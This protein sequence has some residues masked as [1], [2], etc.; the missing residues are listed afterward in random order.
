MDDASAE[1]VPDLIGVPQLRRLWRRTVLA[2]GEAV[3][4]ATWAADQAA[5][6]G[7]GLGLHETMAF[8]HAT[9]PD[10]AAFERWVLACNGGVMDAAR[11]AQVNAVVARAESGAVSP[12]EGLPADLAPVLDADDLRC[13]AEKGYVVLREAVSPEDCRAAAEAIWA[14]TG[15]SPDEP[16]RW[17]DAR[18]REGIFVTLARHPAFEKNRRAPR[19]RAAF[20]QLWGTDDLWVAIDRGGLNPPDRPGRSFAVPPLH[21]DISLVPPFT[22][23]FQGI[24]YLTDTPAEQGA[25]QCVPGFHRRLAAWLAALPGGVDPRDQ[26]FSAEAVRIP[27]RA[28]DMVIWHGALPHG[29]SHNYGRYPRL[30]QYIAYHPPQRGPDRPWR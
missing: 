19:I 13:W 26:D 16:E 10:F 11:V 25:F 1:T 20:A 18:N 9:K 3:D 15:T 7:L 2:C 29:A 27:G 12:A 28:G 30:V 6:Y 21:W 23:Y 17:H 14:F 4:A 8:L 5:I 22:D 24:L